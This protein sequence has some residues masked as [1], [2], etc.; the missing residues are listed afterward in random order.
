MSR[1]CLNAV[2]NAAGSIFGPSPKKVTEGVTYT[3]FQNASDV[4]LYLTGFKA[5]PVSPTAGYDNYWNSFGY[6]NPKSPEKMDAETI[7]NQLAV[8]F[9]QAYS[10]ISNGDA[11]MQTILDAI[12]EYRDGASDHIVRQKQEAAL[13]VV[14]AQGLTAE[15]ITAF[16]ANNKLTTEPAVTEGEAVTA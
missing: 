13:K 9:H 16:L 6:T 12:D 7:G 14:A 3:Y 1:K 15:Q 4:E 8:L 11:K 5:L 2:R 10:L